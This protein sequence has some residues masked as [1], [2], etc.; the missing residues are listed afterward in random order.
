MHISKKERKSIRQ[1]GERDERK[2]KRERQKLTYV[3]PNGH[4]VYSGTQFF[5]VFHIIQEIVWKFLRIN[6]IL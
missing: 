1:L 5:N 2:E 3:V 6:E 4:G